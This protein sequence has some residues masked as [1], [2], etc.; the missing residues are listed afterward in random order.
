MF[1]SAT[2]HKSSYLYEGLALVVSSVVFCVEGENEC[3]ALLVR[4]SIY[5][6]QTPKPESI[7]RIHFLKFHHKL[8][9]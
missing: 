2:M 4:A 6:L 9:V 5:I 7:H 8:F 1:L 3:E